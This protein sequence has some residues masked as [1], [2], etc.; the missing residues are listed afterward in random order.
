MSY[1]LVVLAALLSA[2]AFAAPREGT[3]AEAFTASPTAG[4]HMSPKV[5]ELKK[6]FNALQVQLKSGD[7]ITPG[8]A[9]G[10][11]KLIAMITE[12][13]EPTIFEAHVAD[14]EE[15]DA[16]MD[17]VQKHNDFTES[18][19]AE[20]LLEAA[21]L[22][23]KMNEHNVYARKWEAQTVEY[24]R[25]I[26]IYEASYYN[27]S[28]VCCRREQV[29]VVDLE[30]TA[31]SHQCD[32]TAD[33]AAGCADRADASVTKYTQEPFRAGQA[34]YN[35]WHTGCNN[36]KARE[37]RD[38][39]TYRAEDAECDRLQAN[40]TARRAYIDSTHTRFMANWH[41]VTTSYFPIYKSLRH[42]YT[43][44]EVVMWEREET[45]KMEWN[46]TQLIK[47]LLTGY[48]AGGS[49]DEE[50]RQGCESE[51]TDYHLYLKYPKWVCVLDYK[52]VLPPWPELVDVTPWADECQNVANPDNSPFDN[53]D[54]PADELRPE[55]SNHIDQ[56]APSGEMTPAKAL[57]LHM[58]THNDHQNDAGKN[59]AKDQ[60]AKGSR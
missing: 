14:Q 41:R 55:C 53:C 5:V 54:I 12:D 37:A 48:Q 4:V 44:R 24:N 43:K 18:Y 13:I 56:N 22:R 57:S 42:N 26:P 3:E 6:Q 9:I 10:V 49:F 35:H 16:L 58:S 11:G 2:V 8:V 47:C 45:R 38:L 17:A 15:I 21:D 40:V 32:F 29:A 30:F 34:R 7:K 28:V 31:A 52:P 50:G 33:D 60:H 39:A 19:T 36:E 25:V 59:L 20:L 27:R 46:A 23:Q 51:I 1:K